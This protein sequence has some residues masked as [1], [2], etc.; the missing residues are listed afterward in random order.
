MARLESPTLCYQHF[1][2][3]ASVV[4]RLD[5]FVATTDDDENDNSAICVRLLCRRLFRFLASKHKA[6]TDEIPFLE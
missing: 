3:L 2:V 1:C 5:T 6:C 4:D